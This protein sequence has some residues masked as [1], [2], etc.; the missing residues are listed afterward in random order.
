M[1]AVTTLF[2]IRKDG[3]PQNDYRNG[4]ESDLRGNTFFSSRRQERHIE[5]QVAVRPSRLEKNM[6]QK[7]K[8]YELYKS[9]IFFSQLPKRRFFGMKNYI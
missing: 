4:I 5:I 7:C 9:S 3:G 6:G 1:I 2:L 8:G